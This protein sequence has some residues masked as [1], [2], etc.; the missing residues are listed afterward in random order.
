MHSFARYEPHRPE[1]DAFIITPDRPGCLHRFFDTSPFSPSGRY[2]ALL[3]APFE[4]R[5]NEPGDEATVIVV[6]LETGDDHEVAT[7]RGWEFQMGANLQWGEDDETI[8]FDDVDPQTWRSLGVKLAWRSGARSTFPRGIYHASADGRQAAVTNP[9]AMRRTQAGY[10]VLVPDELVP[11]NQG[12]P[13]DDGLFITD[14]STG[15]TDLVAP[16]RKLVLDGVPKH[17]RDD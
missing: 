8:L 15:K 9:A 16:I 1:C 14:V 17:E 11:L 2:V 10:G 5:V 7:T 4:D 3:Q 13:E 12:L 6:D